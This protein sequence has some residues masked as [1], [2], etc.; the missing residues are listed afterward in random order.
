MKKVVV[1]FL[2]I[3]IYINC[4]FA[5]PGRTD[6][7]GGH[8]VRTP[9]YGYPVGSYHKHNSGSSSN[10]SNNSS[11]S[12]TTYSK[13]TPVMSIEES[14]VNMIVKDKKSIKVN[15][16]NTYDTSYTLKSSNEDVI[17]I[18]GKDIIAVSSGVASVTVNSSVA[19]SKV[20]TVYVK[21]IEVSSINLGTEKIK[22][23]INEEFNTK[24]KIYPS[25][26]SN[27]SLI[28][29][30]S[31]SSIAI[32]DKDGKIT[33]LKSGNCIITV[34]SI[35]NKND[36]L[37]VEVLNKYNSI[38]ITNEIDSINV[39][40]ELKLNYITIPSYLNDKTIVKW[41]SSNDNIT[42]DSNGNIKGIKIGEAEI[43][44]QIDN[45][46]YTK[47]I[48]VTDDSSNI[49]LGG[50]GVIAILTSGVVIYKKSKK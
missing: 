16:K 1:C 31:D 19:G 50:L 38:K 45:V 26:A 34:S 47:K 29:T 48:V 46:K 27:N 9:G 4:V 15:F 32:V 33:G 18:E 5:H 49:V 43:T 30:S 42:I 14:V 25:D 24:V 20:F 35:N 12:N 41:T 22:L 39:S 6:S 17:K 13:P 44:A 10:T 2:F 36:S 3:F 37:K 28:Y 23:Y 11:K 8:Y 21:D 40:Q 7:N